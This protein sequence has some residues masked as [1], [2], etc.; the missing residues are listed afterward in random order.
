MT[1]YNVNL[2]CVIF[3]VKCREN[4]QGPNCVTQGSTSFEKPRGWDNIKCNCDPKD[5]PCFGDPNCICLGD[6][7]SNGNWA[8]TRYN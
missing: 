6:S 8:L 1:V 7:D 2:F 3:K 5:Y 4:C